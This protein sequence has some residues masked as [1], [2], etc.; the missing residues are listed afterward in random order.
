MTSG[1]IYYN[2][3][4]KIL[5]RLAVSTRSLRESGYTGELAWIIDGKDSINGTMAKLAKKMDV[6]I[7]RIDTPMAPLCAKSSL[8]RYTPYEVSLFIDADTVVLTSPDQLL[9]EAEEHGF[10]VTQFSNWI[11]T[12]SKIG[13]RI[14]AWGIVPEVSP[15]DVRKALNYGLAVNTG[16]FGFDK[17]HPLLPH[18]EQITHSAGRVGGPQAPMSRVLD[19]VSC[20]IVVPKHRHIL[21]TDRWN[22]SCQYG[23]SAD[24]AIIHYH[25]GKHCLDEL[26]ACE[27][28]KSRYWSLRHSTSGFEDF[29]GDRRLKFYISGYRDSKSTR[30]GIVKENMTVVTMADQNYAKRLTRNFERWM[31]MPGLREQQFIVGCLR[32]DGT[33]KEYA[34]LR[35]YRNVTML[36]LQKVHESIRT[37]AFYHFLHT[38]PG[39][40]KTPY[41]MKLD[42]DSVPRE[43]RPFK[44]PSL[45]EKI[46]IADPWHYTKVKKDD[47]YETHL[48]HWLNQLDDWWIKEVDPKATPLFPVIT[49]KR[50]MHSRLRSYC[51]IQRTAFSQQVSKLLDG[52]M[53]IPSQDTVTWYVATRLDPSHVE[54]YRFR[55]FITA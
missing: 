43:D 18:W 38:I 40:V 14:R 19:E 10:G 53:L 2:K 55:H 35:A 47:A 1:I 28:W 44:W 7:I 48:V 17:K 23:H 32:A 52:Q 5:T 34:A 50:H 49:E 20:Q 12:G 39:A 8:W 11:T 13:G 26:P 46:V 31:K 24:P 3:G 30:V 4:Q 51:M 41:W 9:A 29:N 27:H 54:A 22:W 36:P 15:R 37:D 45:D 21:W 6:Q 33:E 42:G 16:V 25:G